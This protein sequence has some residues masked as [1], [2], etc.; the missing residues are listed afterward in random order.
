M[1]CMSCGEKEAT[2]H[3]TRISGKKMQKISLCEPC[4]KQPDIKLSKKMATTSFN[5]KSIGLDTV[6]P[7]VTPPPADAQTSFVRKPKLVGSKSRKRDIPEGLWTKC[8]KCGT[9]IYDKELDANLKV[10]PKCEF[11]FNI[12]ARERIHALVETCS[13]EEYDAS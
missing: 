7:A 8:L 9:M 12:S 4:S 5:K 13:F 11:H 2:V 6:E 1:L 3:L 10:C